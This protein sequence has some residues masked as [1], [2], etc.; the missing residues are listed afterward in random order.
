MYFNNNDMLSTCLA[1]CE[2]FH[3]KEIFVEIIKFVVRKILDT[4][5]KNLS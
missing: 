1:A 3:G 2:D 4:N 5:Q